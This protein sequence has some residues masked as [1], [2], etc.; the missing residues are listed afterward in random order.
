MK[1]S[2]TQENLNQGL[3]VVSHIANKNSNLPILAN[4]LIKVEDKILTFSATNLEIGII[5]QVRGKVEKEGD[6]TVDAKLLADYISLLPKE[7]VDLELVEDNLKIECQK[8]KTKIKGLTASDF[9][10]IPKINKENPYII[11]AKS[12]KEAIS[13]VT[14]A[15]SN[16]ETRPEI[17]GVFIKFTNNTAVFAATDGYRLAEKTIDLIEG[18]KEE[19]TII[20]PVRTLQEISRVLGIFKED[21]SLKEVENVE[22]YIS[23]N[24]IV[25]TYNGVE[26]VSRLIEG[27]YPNYSQIVPNNSKTQIKTNINSLIKAVKTASLFTKSGI[28]DIKLEFKKN[29]EIIITSSSSQT[30]ENISTLEAAV[31]GEE[32]SIVLNYRYFLD[33]LQNI[34][35]EEIIIEI[36][37]SNSPCLMKPSGLS[38]YFYII[39]PIKQ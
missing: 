35:T 34:N 16:S 27:E 14:F 24:Q 30:G 18:G 39:M 13:Q 7:R 1:I 8:Q 25:F 10:L 3:M 33:G 37:D 36:N 28:Y 2:C 32:N 23:N 17:S 11:S 21:V 9:P 29:N 19:K 38:D 4:I 6:F 15:V 26:L 20:V 5:A 31:S 12:F 22:I